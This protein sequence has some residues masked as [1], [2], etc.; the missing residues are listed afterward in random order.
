MFWYSAGL[1]AP[2]S[3]NF[4]SRLLLIVWL[5][6]GRNTTKI[7][8]HSSDRTFALTPTQIGHPVVRLNPRHSTCS[9]WTTNKRWGGH[10]GL[11][12]LTASCHFYTRPKVSEVQQSHRQ[13]PGRE[14]E[15]ERCLLFSPK[16]TSTINIQLTILWFAN[17]GCQRMRE[18]DAGSRS[19]LELF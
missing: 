17:K 12:W 2:L 18:E 16:G 5:C 7:C 6:A 11:G 8:L 9:A 15:R 10:P 1:A 13:W 4:L 14:N 3:W 19:V